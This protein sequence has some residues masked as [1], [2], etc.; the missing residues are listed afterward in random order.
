[1]LI[2]GSANLGQFRG[3]EG[4]AHGE[5]KGQMRVLRGH[6]CHLD[7]LSPSF[8]FFFGVMKNSQKLT[9]FF[10]KGIFS[11]KFLFLQ[12]KKLPKIV[13]KKLLFLG[14]RLSSHSFMA[15]GY[16]FKNFLKKE[17]SA[18]SKSA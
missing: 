2:Y 8:F 18:K 3:V 16:T 5:R 17:V 10:G 11:H 15:T 6:N 12:K 9:P 13:M 4:L 7:W 1:M 14:R